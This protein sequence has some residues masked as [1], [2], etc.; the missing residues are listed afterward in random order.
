VPGIA[1]AYL[2]KADIVRHPLVQKIV[3]AYEHHRRTLKSA[4]AET[5][6][7]ERSSLRLCVSAADFVR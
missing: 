3:D 4:A 5:P 2:T 1:F 6:D 7:A